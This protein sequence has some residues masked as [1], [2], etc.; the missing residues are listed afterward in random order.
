M[1]ASVEVQVAMA[2]HHLP[3]T[4]FLAGAAMVLVIKSGKVITGAAVDI[5]KQVD[6]LNR[7]ENAITAD[8]ESQ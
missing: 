3:P 1:L 8:T 7:S 4:C 2:T 5:R 6:R